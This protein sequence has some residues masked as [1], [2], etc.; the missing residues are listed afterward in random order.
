MQLLNER[1]ARVVASDVAVA[2]TRETRRRG[3]LQH[4]A[5]D[6]SSALVLS[7]CFAIHTAFMRFPIDVLFV[8]GQGVVR[9]VVSDLPAWRMAVDVRA[10]TVIEFAA[11]VLARHGVRAGDRVYLSP[12]TDE[13]AMLRSSALRSLR[14]RP[15]G[16]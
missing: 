16:I 4:D 9:R 15:A 14:V 8:D 3:L 7:P 5:L 6:P 2:C 11:G 1:T 13:D 10:R 12:S